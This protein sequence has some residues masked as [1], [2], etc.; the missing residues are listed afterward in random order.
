MGTF[1]GTFCETCVVQKGEVSGGNHE[2]KNGT[3]YI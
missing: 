2:K 3:F 1:D